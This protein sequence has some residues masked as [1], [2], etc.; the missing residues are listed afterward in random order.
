M[1]NLILANLKSD[2]FNAGEGCGK[3]VLPYARNTLL[4]GLSQLTTGHCG[5]EEKKD[6]SVQTSQHLTQPLWAKMWTLIAGKLDDARCPDFAK[7]IKEFSFCLNTKLH[8]EMNIENT[9]VN[10]LEK[11]KKVKTIMT[12]HTQH[13]M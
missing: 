12:R 6:V 3:S 7:A 8:E 9:D 11:D 13:Q 2:E 4:M 1:L 5:A 10:L